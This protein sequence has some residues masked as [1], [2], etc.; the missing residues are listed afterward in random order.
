VKAKWVT[1]FAAKEQEKMGALQGILGRI[2]ERNKKALAEIL[3][4]ETKVF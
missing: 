3:E 4:Y 2:R 1:W